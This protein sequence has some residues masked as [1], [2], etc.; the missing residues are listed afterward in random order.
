MRLVVPAVALYLLF[1]LAAA[2]AMPVNAESWQDLKLLGQRAE[3][4]DKIQES[5]KY[6][7]K[8]LSLLPRDDYRNRLEIEYSLI[9]N[10]KLLKKIEPMFTYLE[11]FQSD[12]L[13][14]QK[15]AP[16]QRDPRLDEIIAEVIGLCD[17]GMKQ[18]Y[19]YRSRV[20]LGLRLCETAVRISD[21]AFANGASPPRRANLA[22]AYIATNQMPLALI[23]MDKLLERLPKDHNLRQNY[24][25]NRACLKAKMG[26]PEERERMFEDMKKRRGMASACEIL[27]KAQFW[28]V[29]YPGSLSTLQKGLTAPNIKKAEKVKLLKAL[30][31]TQAD[32]GR[33][34][35]SEKSLRQIAD[36]LSDNKLDPEYGPTM[37]SLS[38]VL[39]LQNR[40][41]E[42]EKV[43]KRG[44]TDAGDADGEAD[45]FVTEKDR[46]KLRSG[47][48]K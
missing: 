26:K 1:V 42:A 6:F 21:I 9:D 45:F 20:S 24:E 46:A 19:D 23:Q 16:K 33:Y 39:K 37:R 4:Q 14:L 28:A 22:R 10:Y 3:R 15:S 29:D 36:L 38:Q 32:C 40:H 44:F 11:S 47:E 18:P 2:C 25:L 35:D 34:S 43:Y 41:A 31:L 13:A 7:E 48:N 12:L 17:S 5:I 30:A 27:G 8:A